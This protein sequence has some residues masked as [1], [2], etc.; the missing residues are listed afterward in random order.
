MAK[1]FLLGSGIA[2]LGGILAAFDTGVQPTSDMT[3]MLKAV[4]AAIIGGA[5][6]VYGALAGAFLIGIIEN[7]GVWVIPTEWKPAISFGLLITFLIW[8][9]KGIFRR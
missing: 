2:G 6:N 3:F 4:I 5:G 7:V 8:R 9:P 1:V